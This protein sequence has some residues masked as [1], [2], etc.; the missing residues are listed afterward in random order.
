MKSSRYK[1]LC[2]GTVSYS[3]IELK[4]A[5][6]TS[7]AKGPFAVLNWYQSQC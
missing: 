2:D 7:Y 5:L 4:A 1:I 3:D 6:L